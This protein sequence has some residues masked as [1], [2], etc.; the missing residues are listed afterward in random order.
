MIQPPKAN[1]N[2]PP[3]ARII[4]LLVWRK[5]PSGGILFREPQSLTS[6]HRRSHGVSSL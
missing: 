3:P 2:T 4:S 5:G 1:N 6:H